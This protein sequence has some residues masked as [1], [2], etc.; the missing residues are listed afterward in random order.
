MLDVVSLPLLV[1]RPAAVFKHTL[2]PYGYT[3]ALSL[4]CHST[5]YKVGTVQISFISFATAAACTLQLAPVV[6]Y[7]TLLPTGDYALVK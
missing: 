1:A 5:Y 4:L 6:Q 2:H 3:T 7:N